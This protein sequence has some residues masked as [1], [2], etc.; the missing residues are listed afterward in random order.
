MVPPTPGARHTLKDPRNV[1][2][3]VAQANMRSAIFQWLQET[4]FD[5]SITKQTLLSPSAKDF[6]SIF[7]HLIYILDSSFV[8]GE[9]GRKF[10]DEVVLSLRALQYPFADSIDKKW[11]TTPSAQYSWPSILAMLHW[12]T[13]L[14]RVCNEL[15]LNAHV[16]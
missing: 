6:R 8:F 7:I 13:E 12:V 15:N 4:Q 9:K 3:K 2:D 14:S 10:E 16:D 1:R 11:L 5:G